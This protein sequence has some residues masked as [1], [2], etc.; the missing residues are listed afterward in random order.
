VCRSAESQSTVI[1]VTAGRPRSATA[2]V[3]RGISHRCSGSKLGTFRDDLGVR[4]EW[5]TV[6]R[7]TELLLILSRTTLERPL[8]YVRTSILRSRQPMTQIPHRAKP[9]V[10]NS[11]KEIASY[12][13]RGVRT[14]QRWEREL[15]LPV[16]RIGVGSRSP[17][18]A[19][20]HEVRS[21]LHT[22]SPGK[23]YP[24]PVV[25]PAARGARP[26]VVSRSIELTN[27]LASATQENRRLM[28]Q[29][30]RGLENL[31]R[32]RAEIRETRMRQVRVRELAP[33]S[34][35]DAAVRKGPFPIRTTPPR[36]ARRCAAA[37]I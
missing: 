24:A 9:N 2:G 28:N 8:K 18:F 12:L 16:H 37:A 1:V 13:G 26:S 4:H 17:V 33:A 19:F 25:T 15:Q 36:Q 10:L 14:V 23:G 31:R 20:E 3:S 32:T 7:Q 22:T 5:F 30:A 35:G 6:R 34:F 21:W 29:L 11:W 27:R